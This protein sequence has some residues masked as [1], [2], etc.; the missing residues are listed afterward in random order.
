MTIDEYKQE[1]EK[2]ENHFS[3]GKLILIIII[4]FIIFAFVSSRISVALKDRKAN[5]SDKVVSTDMGWKAEKKNIKALKKEDSDIEGMTKYDKYKKG[6]DPRDGSDTDGDGLS[7]KDEIEVYGTD[8]L[9]M[10]TSGDLYTDGEKVKKGLSLTEKNDYDGEVKYKGN[11]SNGA[12]KLDATDAEGRFAIVTDITGFDSLKGRKVYKEYTV[13]HFAGTLKV[14]VSKV[15]KKNDIAADK[16]S[17]Y[18]ADGGNKAKQVKTSLDGNVFTVDKKFSLGLYTIYV[19]DKKLVNLP[20][21]SYCDNAV[22]E[23]GGKGF[24]GIAYSIPILDFISGQPAIEY[25]DSDNKTTVRKEKEALV[26]LVNLDNT[27]GASTTVKSKRIKPASQSE[28]DR[29]YAF[30]KK[31]Y[32]A[33]DAVA[34][35]GNV[36]NFLFVYTRLS[37]GTKMLSKE[38]LSYIN[39]DT[40]NSGFSVKKDAF[41]FQNL[42][43]PDYAQGGVCAGYATYTASVYNTGSPAVTSAEGV[44]DANKGKVVYPWD[45]TGDAFK[46]MRTK[47][48]LH[49]FKDKDYINSHKDREGMFSKNLSDN[50]KTFRNTMVYYWAKS[51]NASL[52]NKLHS[53]Y[54]Y[55][56]GEDENSQYYRFN[57][58]GYSYS[59]IEWIKKQIKAGKIV[60][61]G[62]TEGLEDPKDE[63]QLSGHMVNLYGYM[64]CDDG[65]TIFKVYDCNYPDRTDLTMTV[66]KVDITKNYMTELKK[67]GLTKGYAGAA[68]SGGKKQYSFIYKYQP[69]DNDS[70]YIFTNVKN[71]KYWF[72][73]IEAEKNGFK[74][75]AKL[76]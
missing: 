10:S 70:R 62:M 24:D 25:L 76:N 71:G 68:V 32:P 53:V 61:V 28:I 6:L 55:A 63:A 34:H 37:T 29:K 42:S 19:T 8:P 2:H 65:R 35:P 67:E 43:D 56:N 9:K 27:M 18:I 12:V 3:I 46:D 26:A 15:V 31:V 49:S 17:I 1:T 36:A 74:D 40:V 48:K 4:G 16:L 7:D 5:K 45:I 75:M 21:S 57:D 38:Q 39:R 47:G 30:F 66:K 44:N 58:S 13:D 20:A 41:P 22:P 73:V 51:N 54:Y 33:G 69:D 50:D 52:S 64:D 59:T 14:D 72:H 23:A 60:S 11:H